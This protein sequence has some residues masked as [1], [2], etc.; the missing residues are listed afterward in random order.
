MREKSYLWLMV[1]VLLGV[2]LA[3][4]EQCYGQSRKEREARRAAEEAD[5]L[6]RLA[7]IVSSGLRSAEEVPSL[8]TL[9]S[10]TLYLPTIDTLSGTLLLP[11]TLGDTLRVSALRIDS[12][13]THLLADSLGRE[14]TLDSLRAEALAELLPN[15]SMTIDTLTT[16]EL[17]LDSV[18]MAS[19]R[20]LPPFDPLQQEGDSLLSPV[21][22][23]NFLFRDTIGLSK[24]TAISALLP[25]TAQIYNNQAWK[26]P[27]GYTAIG[28]PLG[29][30]IAQHKKYSTLRN[31]Y[32]QL[33]RHD[34]PRS[35]IDPVQTEMIRHNTYRQLL[36]A[37]AIVSYAA[38]LTDGV[39]N[40]PSEVN[41]IKKATTL[42]MV[43]PGAGQI[44]NGSY[45][46]V[47]I[48]VGG[49]V[50]MGYIIDWNNRGYQRFKLA[51]DLLTDGDDT[52]VDEFNGRYDE[53]FLQNLK[54]QYRRNRD[55][56][57]IG[58]VGVYLF[59]IMDAHI[60]AHMQDYDISD[61]LSINVSPEL[62]QIGTTVRGAESTLGVGLS[63]TF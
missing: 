17:R 23:H 58:M 19:L 53:G 52:T 49:M 57:I 56:S 33:I 42:S 2:M 18:T 27:V 37:G 9:A 45:W 25:G 34:A 15:L 29:L 10:D 62:R 51:Y 38:L 46:K 41:S 36:F 59:N 26:I 61:D 6:R 14:V 30:G 32:D 22:R 31:E 24:L 4:P 11:D 40:Y 50:S 13:G 43:F 3:T 21:I 48:F 20:G 63:L 44:Y 28:V 55:L 5:S 35:E 60:D 12:L 54:N 16:Q 8:D 47:P 39:I 7:F 1:V